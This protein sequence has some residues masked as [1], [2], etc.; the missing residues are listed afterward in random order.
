[1]L[2]EAQPM[3]APK[4]VDVGGIRTRY[5]E[6]GQGQP[7]VLVHGGTYGT[8]YNAFHWSKNFGELASR[9]HVYAIDKI[10]MGHTDNPEGDAGYTMSRTTD[11]VRD[12]LTTMG[13]RGAVLV[14]HSRGGLPVARIAV[15]NPELVSALVI[16]D[17]NTLAAEHPSTPRDFYSSFNIEVTGDPDEAFVLRE[18]RANSYSPE[19]ITPEFT[20]EVLAVARLPKT[21]TA[22]E[23]MRLRVDR[24]FRADVRKVKNETLDAI[25]DRSLDI[26]VLV[27]WGLNDPSAPVAL[28]YDL[29]Q[30]IAMSVPRS[31]LMV[32]NQAGHYV[33]REHARQVSRAILEVAED[34]GVSRQ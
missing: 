8:Y 10:G 6:A 11:H 12:F 24:Q 29:F 23:A 27:I 15:T 16:V 9:A 28:G 32:F 26:P 31:R 21:Q 22:R 20:T 14:G 18:A 33:Y 25:R 4:F 17:S 7:I 3:G 19:H 13:I 2:T 30:H 5:F 34:V 1:M